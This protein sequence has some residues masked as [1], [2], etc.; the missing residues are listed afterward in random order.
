MHAVHLLH[1]AE[2]ALHRVLATAL[3]GY[4]FAHFFLI[5]ATQVEEMLNE[6]TIQKVPVVAWGWG[7]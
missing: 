5:L 7:G 3:L 1:D 2:Q 6:I 4:R